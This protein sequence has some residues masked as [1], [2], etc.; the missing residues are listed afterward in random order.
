M[1]IMNT[2][3]TINHTGPIFVGRSGG[4]GVWNQNGGST[5]FNDRLF[6]GVDVNGTFAT[7]T[8]TV[9]ISNGGVMSLRQI[10]PWQ[11]ADDVWLPSN[12]EKN[13][14]S[15]VNVD[16]GTLQVQ[17][18]TEGT[19][20]YFL[21]AKQSKQ[22]NVYIMA[23]GL[24]VDTNGG[25][26][27]IRVPLQTGAAQPGGTAGG[28]F[29]K[30]G[31]GELSLSE[32]CIYTGPTTVTTGT[33]RVPGTKTL[34]TTSVSVANGATLQLGAAATLTAPLTKLNLETGST[35]AF[36]LT[37]SAIGTANTIS[38]ATL[39]NSTGLN[40][41]IGATG[42]SLDTAHAY[43]LISGYNNAA[44]GTA[45]VT[46]N[47]RGYTP[48]LTVGNAATTLSITGALA[49][50]TCVWEN[51]TGNGS[52]DVNSS[53]N[54]DT[55]DSKFMELD[56]VVFN[57]FPYISNTPTT[58]VNVVGNIHPA[59]ITIDSGTL[60]YNFAGTGSIV[61]IGTTVTKRGAATA[62]F[63]NAGGV[64]Y[65][66]MTTLSGG[67]L[68]FQCGNVTL[69]G[70]VTLDGGAI[71]AMANGFGATKLTIASDLVGTGSNGLTKNGS[72][73]LILQGTST[74]SGPTILQ[75]GG[76]VQISDLAQLGSSSDDPANLVLDDI[77]HYTGPAT[78]LTRGF[79][80]GSHNGGLWID[81]DLT[82]SNYSVSTG[83][84]W[85]TRT[86]AGTWTINQNP[87]ALP[88]QFGHLRLEEGLTVVHGADLEV[89]DFWLGNMTTASL[90]MDGG[91]KLHSNVN[92]NAGASDNGA[93]GNATLTMDNASISTGGWFAIGHDNSTCSGTLTMTHGSSIDAGQ[94]FHAGRDGAKGKITLSD[95]SS[96]I[97][98]GYGYVGE[99]GGQMDLTLND[100]SSMTF[101]N[102]LR[103][104]AAG[105]GGVT[106]V[107]MHGTSSISSGNPGYESIALGRDGANK[108]TITMDGNNA[109]FDRL[110]G[111][112][113]ICGGPLEVGR[114]GN[115][116]AYGEIDMS[117]ASYITTADYV[118]FG[119]NQ[120]T[121]KLIMSGVADLVSNNDFYLGSWGGKGTLTMTDAA[122]ITVV[123]GMGLARY[124]DSGVTAIANIDMSGS[125]EIHGGSWIN[126]GAFSNGVGT[127]TM[128]QGAWVELGT[129]LEDQWCNFGYD[130]GKATIDMSGG[131][132]MTVTNKGISLGERPGAVGLITLSQGASITV[133]SSR[134]ERT[135]TG[136][137]SD[138]DNGAFL[139]GNQG[140]NGTLILLD[141]SRVVGVGTD[142][143]VGNSYND[144]DH[145]QFNFGAGG[146][147]KVIGDGA[148]LSTTGAGRISIGNDGGLG[149]WYQ[150]G[151]LTT[152]PNPVILGEYDIKHVLHPEWGAPTAGTGYLYLQ[153]GVFE[154]PQITTHSNAAVAGTIG[155]VYFQGGT[156]QASQDNGNFVTSDGNGSVM[157]LLVGKNA[158]TGLGA[159][160]DTQALSV[161]I[162]ETLSHD[163]AITTGLDGG[164]KKLGTGDLTL[165][166][167]PTY[168][169]NTIVNAGA[170]TVPVLYTPDATVFVATGASLT[171]TSITANTLTIGGTP[172]AA[173]SAVPE[174]SALVLLALAGLSALLAAWRR[175]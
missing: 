116:A 121:G 2:S 1:G 168:T 20:E 160:I 130:T 112:H 74:Y 80:S 96:I 57:G 79:T 19:A 148:Q 51:W 102:R 46:M 41:V 167:S 161:T 134:P 169:G 127:L 144:W 56:N 88:D 37:D 76:R 32:S 158:A 142:I 154:A 166:A 140:G 3:G 170:L 94:D 8:S 162:N 147:V 106:T 77:L 103:L 6:L 115:G 136:A 174:P 157:S 104:A 129:R 172:T 33:L 146:I 25:N 52:W 34:A 86:G 137:N 105:N 118:M 35:L 92:F 150:Q 60:N 21:T 14:S 122:H 18:D 171:A 82:W 10:C 44:A 49:S 175:K 68:N 97:C 47:I 126:L 70:G 139:I 141:G 131:S 23:G 12:Y 99:N 120:S 54:W 123:Y 62:T 125:S 89:N 65:T 100:S 9:N 42:S 95:G 138:F 163:P 7:S 75:D 39:P 93:A 84:S 36:G 128:S 66:G 72:G 45:T 149:T 17:Y 67:S 63:A 114:W 110:S 108:G 30:T 27:A 50:Q 90:T 85:W 71:G 31:D 113:I 53:D 59:S 69:T 117:G 58:N 159:V 135:T 15:T 43:T 22:Y 48:T 28:G 5:T 143:Q 101:V 98:R 107:A 78:T 124:D 153:G 111:S 11:G 151:G 83:G 26:A 173:A 13:Y 4:S 165:T 156:L 73:T 132:R 81:H 164:L 40:F 16:G 133:T 155:T 87:G 109:T 64:Y 152:T 29:E 119:T 61:G 55:T 38:T 24:T 145:S 91:A